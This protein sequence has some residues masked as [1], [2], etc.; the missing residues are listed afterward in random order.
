MMEHAP[1]PWT[2]DVY[3]RMILDANNSLVATV[4]GDG[5]PLD[6][7]AAFILEACNN[8][9]RVVAERDALR[10]A[11]KSVESLL[12]AKVAEKTAIARVWWPQTLELVRAALAKG[13]AE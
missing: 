13:G 5:V 7:R 1:T 2:Y 9:E 3:Y 6:E 4:S 8:Y 11:C 12:D 10:E